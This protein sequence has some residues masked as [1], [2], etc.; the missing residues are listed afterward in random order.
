MSTTL[1]LMTFNT[2]LFGD[3]VRFFHRS[4]SF[5]DDDRFKH[6]CECIKDSTIC[7]A[8]II[9]IQEMWSS[10]YVEHITTHTVSKLYPTN[11]YHLASEGI[12]HASNAPGLLLMA[13]ENVTFDT[14]NAVYFDY[15]HE[16]G[17]S[18]FDQKQDAITGKGYLKVPASVNGVDFTLLT[19]HMPTNA[20]AFP[21]TLNQCFDALAAAVPDDNSPVLLMGDF[22]IYEGKVDK[23]STLN[24][25]PTFYDMWIGP[26]GALGQAGL[27]DGYRTQNSDASTDPGYSIVGTTNTTWKHF[28][29]KKVT[30]NP[31][32]YDLQRIDYIMYRGFTPVANS[33]QVQGT[34]NPTPPAPP[35]DYSDSS[36]KWIFHDHDDNKTRDLSDHYPLTGTLTL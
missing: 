16:F 7:S 24:P 15:I 3:V 9:A 32:E 14:K 21:D 11:W 20:E 1:N 12:V 4:V 36:N 2:H 18:H 10:K 27:I 35:T 5:H 13:R 34:P 29:E 23:S 6:L 31:P 22:N 17:P 30:K 28:N 8:D 25:Q 19:T 26:N 33:I